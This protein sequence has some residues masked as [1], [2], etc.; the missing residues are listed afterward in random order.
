MW[1]K[2]LAAILVILARADVQLHWNGGATDELRVVV[3]WS[4]RV[5]FDRSFDIIRN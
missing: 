5:L 2:V 3:K 1:K 4:D